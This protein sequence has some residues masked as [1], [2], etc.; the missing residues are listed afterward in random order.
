[1]MLHMT[2]NN[3]GSSTEE[4]EVSDQSLRDLMLLPSMMEIT[5]GQ[6]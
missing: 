4:L 3:G 1:M 5:T 6:D 2:R